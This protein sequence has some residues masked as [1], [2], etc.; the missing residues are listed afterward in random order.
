M[1]SGAQDREGRSG[2]PWRSWLPS[3]LGAEVDDA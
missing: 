1:V 3:V 2:L